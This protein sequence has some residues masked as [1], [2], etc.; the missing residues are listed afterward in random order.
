M[1]N[2]INKEQSFSEILNQ[3]IDNIQSGV[4][5]SG[6]AFPAA[7]VM[8]ERMGCFQARCSRCPSGAGVAWHYHFRA[9]WLKLHIP[10]H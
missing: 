2:E 6:D 4:L 9:W 8:A 5:K 10:G 7:Q 3:V 1:F